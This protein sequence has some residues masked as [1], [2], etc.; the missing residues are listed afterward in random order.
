MW[1]IPAIAVTR[2][3]TIPIALG[4]P[5]A[6][7]AVSQWRLTDVLEKDSNGEN[8]GVREED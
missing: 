4:S 1:R 7:G 6:L 8:G 2:A 3:V 5:V